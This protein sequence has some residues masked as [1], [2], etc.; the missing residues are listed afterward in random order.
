MR[1]LISGASGLVGTALS[2][3]LASEGHTVHKLARAGTR[4]VREPRAV[5]WYLEGNEFD[6]KAA[7]GA[8]AVVHLAGVSIASG[9]W[10]KAR[11]K[12]IYDSRV[13]VTH[14]LVGNLAKLQKPPRVFLCASAVGYY[15]NRGDEELVEESPPGNDFLAGLAQ[16][17]EAAAAQAEGFGARAAMLRF[18]VVLARHGGAL[19][20]MALPIRLGVGGR[21]GSGKQWMSWVTL[22]EVVS[23]VRFAL[24]NDSARGP[25]N[26]VAPSPVTNAEFTKCLARVL[27]R[28]AML[29]VPGFA[30][31]LLL[32][33]MAQALLLSS[34]R[35]VP[36]KLQ[37]LGYTFVS[38]QL[39][40]A[41]AAILQKTKGV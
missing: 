22:D 17:W 40:P 34:Q 33:E 4:A 27:H 38:P 39:E 2:S 3:A 8:D 19:P 23:I 9:R 5:R 20:R 6:G 41:L 36:R 16:E 26:A 1:I 10:S 14:F 7:E 24:G 13:E 29:P 32:G 12:E 37:R 28:P 25:L 15:G 11:K 21:I 30:L 31:R 35:V 18:G